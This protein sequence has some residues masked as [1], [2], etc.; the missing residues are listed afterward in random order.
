MSKIAR[1]AGLLAAAVLAI[2]GPLAAEERAKAPRSP[3]AASDQSLAP[4]LAAECAR[5]GWDISDKLGS[6]PAATP[7][8]AA[9]ARLVERLKAQ[10]PD[11]AARADT[12]KAYA[13]DYRAG[14][15]P[16]EQTRICFFGRKSADT[17]LLASMQLTGGKYSLAELQRATLEAEAKLSDRPPSGG[18]KAMRRLFFGAN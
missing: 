3:A 1:R 7:H 11:V 9:T 12:V 13:L 17:I 8:A 18:E 16:Q 2:A 14:L 5:A 15:P 4:A 10:K 6:R